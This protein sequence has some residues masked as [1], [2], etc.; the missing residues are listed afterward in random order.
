VGF[1]HA[2]PELDELAGA[3]PATGRRAASTAAEHVLNLQ[4]AAGNRAVTEALH[5]RVVQREPPRPTPAPARPSTNGA[6][7]DGNAEE[8]LDDVLARIEASMNLPERVAPAEVL[9]ATTAAEFSTGELDLGIE[10]TW[11]RERLDFTKAARKHVATSAKG[12]AAT[13]TQGPRFDPERR[14]ALRR[15]VSLLAADYKT[16][17]DLDEVAAIAKRGS[18]YRSALTKEFGNPTIVLN[19]TGARMRSSIFDAILKMWIDLQDG[20]VGELL[21]TF[22][23]HGGGGYFSGVDWDAVDGNELISLSE[24][25]ADHNVHVIYVMDTCRAGLLAGAA[26]GQALREIKSRLA[27][28]PADLRKPLLARQQYLQEL[29]LGAFE[30]GAASH[31]VGDKARDEVKKRSDKNRLAY[32]EALVELSNRNRAF[33]AILGR[34]SLPGIP[35]H[36]VLVE[37]QERLGWNVLSAMAGSGR[38][39]ASTLHAAARMLDAANDVINAALE[40]LDQDVRAASPRNPKGAGPGG[41]GR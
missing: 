18:P 4:A 1:R 16:G 30:V 27:R 22:S 19:P 13:G 11:K 33:K 3:G 7:K 34:A 17:G 40:R 14:Y 37:L 9:T 26:Q 23:G 20:E 25:A 24:L 2:P 8:T 12:G 10:K 21:V 38:E 29:R 5:P 41:T 39:V 31:A 6:A 35:D 36:K 15:S 28:V 32:F